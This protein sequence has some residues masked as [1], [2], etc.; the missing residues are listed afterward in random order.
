MS[1][2]LNK[3]QLNRF[4]YKL[5]NDVLFLM[6]LSFG[7]M[8]LSEAA[9][10]G[11]L[12]DHISFTKLILAI[13][14]VFGL[15]IYLREKIKKAEI[16]EIPDSKPEKKT[17]AYFLTAFI[18]VLLIFSIRHFNWAILA[19]IIITTLFL[20]YYLFEIFFRENK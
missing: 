1:D 13:F 16:A 18:F 15:I 4:F 6:L 3:E 14:L 10:P 17:Y 9:L 5:L 12:S 8:L 2:N 20:L 11:I 19:V 7:A